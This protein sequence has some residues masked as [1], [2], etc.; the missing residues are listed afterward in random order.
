MRAVG[1][2]SA[3]M[4]DR[5]P[6]AEALMTTLLSLAGSTQSRSSSVRERIGHFWL[7]RICDRQRQAPGSGDRRSRHGILHDGQRRRQ[8]YPLRTKASGI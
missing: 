2:L 7:H 1:A 8:G 6:S 5:S 3:S 4:D